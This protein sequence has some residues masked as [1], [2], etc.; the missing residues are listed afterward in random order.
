MIIRKVEDRFWEI[1]FLRG[2]AVIFMIFFHIIYDLNYFSIAD[3]EISSGLIFYIGRITAT[4]FILLAGIS[5]S[6][7]YSRVKKILKLKDI[8]LKFIKRGL[9]I[10]FLGLIISVITWFYIPRGFIIFGILH[11][12]GASILLSLIF[13]K[14]KLNNIIFGIF[15]IIVGFYLKSLTFDFN[16]LIPLGFIPNNFWTVDYFPL[17]PWFGIILIGIS[18]GNFIYPNCKRIFSIIDLS[19][20]LIVKSFCYLGRN[21]LL[22]YFIHQPIIIV[23][24][25]ILLL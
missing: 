2:M 15:F 5:L 9:K 3:Y 10:I 20:N 1:D 21:S 4:I 17:F 8:L 13:I 7:S 14:Y 22:I 16:F 18:I 23:L 24:I 6:I 25:T 11:F 19:K 12:I